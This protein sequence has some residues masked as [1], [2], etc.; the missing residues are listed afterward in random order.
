MLPHQQILQD[1]GPGPSGQPRA[2]AQPDLAVRQGLA[3]LLEILFIIP[4]PGFQP[5]LQLANGPFLFVRARP[6]NGDIFLPGGDLRQRLI[7]ILPAP[8]FH[9][10]APILAS[11]APWRFNDSST[12]GS[13]SLYRARSSSSASA[14]PAWPRRS[15]VSL[16]TLA[17]PSTC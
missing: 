8:D 1:L 6:A 12:R 14:S 5:L 11:L 3:L 17:T 7:R 2:P 13:R 15:S 9:I 4:D 16:A 10:A